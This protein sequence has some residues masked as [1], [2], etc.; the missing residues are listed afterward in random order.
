MSAFSWDQWLNLNIDT[1][2]QAKEFTK[3]FFNIMSN[4]IPHEIK[5]I[6]PR[7]NS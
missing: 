6:K 5:K 7:D 1:N 2:C 3:C 4:F